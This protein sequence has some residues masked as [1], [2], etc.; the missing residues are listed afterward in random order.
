[1]T[2]FLNSD[3]ACFDAQLEAARINANCEHYNDLFNPPAEILDEYGQPHEEM[4]MMLA[5]DSPGSSKDAGD[6]LC[7][8]LLERFSHDA[9]AV[10]ALTAPH[11]HHN[12]DR[13]QA[14]QETAFDE[15]AKRAH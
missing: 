10:A 8:C 3:A 5:M 4:L 6:A 7:Q 15:G 13:Y 11:Y 14:G 12:E 1:M 2:T 9:V